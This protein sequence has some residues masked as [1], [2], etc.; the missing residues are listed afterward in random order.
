MTPSTTT[1]N[2]MSFVSRA[3]VALLFILYG[4]AKITGFSG[5]VGYITSNNLPLPEVAAVIAILV[6]VGL[7]LLLLVGYQTRWVALAMFLYVIVLPFIFHAYW[8][9]PPARMTM[10]KL[11]FYKDLAI[12]GGL[13]AFATWGA[14][15]WSVD[16]MRARSPASGVVSAA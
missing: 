9:V 12:A 6:E 14:G 7:G 1:S 2:L 13:L 4:F 15:G 3:L 8:S 10:E 5:T 11:M 16:G